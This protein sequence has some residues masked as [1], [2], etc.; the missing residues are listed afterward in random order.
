M[1]PKSQSKQQ[2]H[3]QR[4]RSNA[5]PVG[6]ALAVLP[7]VNS[8]KEKDTRMLELAPVWRSERGNLTFKLDMFP[9]QWLDPLHPRTIVIKMR[10]DKQ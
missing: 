7:Y 5:A 8:N 10:G 3:Q 2:E 4:E 6:D 9:L 1:P